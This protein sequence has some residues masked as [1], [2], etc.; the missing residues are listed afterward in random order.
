MSIARYKLIKKKPLTVERTLPGAWVNGRWVEGSLESFEIQGHYYPLTANQKMSLPEAF[1]SKSTYKMHSTTELYSVREKNS[2]SADKVLI[3][4]D[5]YEVQEADHF[6]M[7]IR[8]HWEF[9]LVR[10]EQSAG[11]VT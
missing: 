11:G 10:F 7:G 9:L 2:Q 3:K 4:E 8:D 1:R 5:W 6:S